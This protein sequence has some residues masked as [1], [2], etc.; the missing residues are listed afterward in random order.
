MKHETHK[1]SEWILDNF[2]IKKDLLDLEKIEEHIEQYKEKHPLT[3]KSILEILTSQA[4]SLFSEIVD[5]T[6]VQESYFFRDPS[7]FNYLQETY[8]PSIIQEKN[9]NN[10][11]TLK[12]WSAAASKGEEIYTLAI[13]LDLLEKNQGYRFDNWHIELLGTDLNSYALDTAGSAIYT[14]YSLRSISNTII[15]TYFTKTSENYQLAEKLKQHVKFKKFNLTSDP[16]PPSKQ[17]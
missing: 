3:N 7:L 12:I 9:K 14:R 17:L 10:N 4:D 15:S 2:G 16:P 5:L 1:I 6:T 13:I 11:K 8:L